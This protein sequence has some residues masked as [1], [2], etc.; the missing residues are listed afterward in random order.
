MTARPPRRSRGGTGSVGPRRRRSDRPAWNQREIEDGT[1]SSLTEDE[2]AC[3]EELRWPRGTAKRIA[4][5][6]PEP[7]A[8]KGELD[9]IMRRTDMQY[10]TRMTRAAETGLLARPVIPIVSRKQIRCFLRE[11]HPDRGEVECSNGKK[12]VSAFV[13]S[14]M[15][16]YCSCSPGCALGHP[17]LRTWRNAESARREDGGPPDEQLCYLCILVQAQEDQLLAMA[18]TR[19]TTDVFELFGVIVDEPGEYRSTSCLPLE[20]NGR[21]TGLR[22]PIPRVEISNYRWTKGIDE[23]D[24]KV[25]MVEESEAMVFRDG[26]A[27]VPMETTTPPSPRISSD[28]SRGTQR[29]RTR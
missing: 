22:H 16:D 24:Q 5:A 17:L 28:P 26:P 27:A 10:S 18:E 15:M 19:H 13:R 4:R 23:F 29:R 3:L 9:E 2:R 21:M 6:H 12:C 11:P 25:W 7:L 1:G 8:S 14:S 20:I